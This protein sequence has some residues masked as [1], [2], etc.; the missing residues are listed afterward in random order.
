M[1]AVNGQTEAL[2][3]LLFY[4]ADFEQLDETPKTSN[5]QIVGSKTVKHQVE[6]YPFAIFAACFFLSSSG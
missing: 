4:K 6:S 2:E 3:T 1:A 5:D